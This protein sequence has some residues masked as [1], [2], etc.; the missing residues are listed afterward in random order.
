[1]SV[2]ITQKDNIFVLHLEGPNLALDSHA[3]IRDIFRDLKEK[4]PAGVIMDLTD[5]DRVDSLGLGSLISGRL[6]LRSKCEIHLCCLSEPVES[7]VRHSRMD[8]LFPLHDSVDEA[9]T[10][11]QNSIKD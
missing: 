11:V 2:K 3:E 4:S 8:L 5:V 10:A 9:V 1:M 7:V 6:S